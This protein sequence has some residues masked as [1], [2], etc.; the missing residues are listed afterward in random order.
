MDKKQ[1][2]TSYAKI[3]SSQWY[4]IFWAFAGNQIS[5]QFTHEYLKQDKLQIS[6]LWQTLNK[7]LLSVTF[8]YIRTITKYHIVIK[9]WN[10]FL[11][12]VKPRLLLAMAGTKCADVF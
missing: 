9:S 11:K 1:N 7:S 6:L 4:S 10:I 8:Y 3:K 12:F 5:F 2:A